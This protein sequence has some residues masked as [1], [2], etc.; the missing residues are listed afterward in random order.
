MPTWPYPR[1]FSHRLGGALAPEN[2]LAGL[3]LSQRLGIGGVECDIK[4]SCDGHLFVLHD[5][6]LERTTN[7]HGDAEALTLE[8][9]RTLD[10]GIRHH[11]AFQG[12]RIPTLEELA[13]YTRA[14][15]IAVNLEIKPAAGR[16]AVTGHAL[17]L[18]A[19]RLWHGAARPPL[20][21]SFSTEALLAARDTEAALPRALLVE[22]MEESVLAA[23]ER[24]DAAALHG[25]FA[26][27]DA[28]WIA[29]LQH[30]GRA[31]MAYTVDDPAI[32]RRLTADGIDML[33]TDR[34]DRIG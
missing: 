3:A 16:E 11:P 20:L 28:G 27:L 32:A 19:A 10:A 31:V 22:N 26:G 8:Q 9:L 18:A 17:A 4:L 30:A 29:R 14:A 7:G 34:P 13:T 1:I 12:E 5:D 15:N 23:L 6:T 24:V 25:P 33:C 2:T 21:S